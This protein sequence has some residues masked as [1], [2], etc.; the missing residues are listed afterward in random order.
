MCQATWLPPH[1]PACVEHP[2]ALH[3]RIKRL[4]WEGQFFRRLHEWCAWSNQS[5]EPYANQTPPPPASSYKQPLCCGTYGLLCQ[6]WSPLPLSLYREASF[7]SLLSCLLNSSLLKTTSCVS[8]SFY[9]ICMRQESWYSSTQQSHIKRTA[10]PSTSN[11]SAQNVNNAKAGK[12]WYR[13]KYY[14]YDPEAWVP[15]F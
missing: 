9:P 12:S 2:G 14:H 1:I 4:G 15:G 13:P 5:P 11:Y 3:L 7:F 10:P 8:M 6:L